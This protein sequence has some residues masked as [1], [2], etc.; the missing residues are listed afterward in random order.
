M[1]MKLKSSF[2]VI[3]SLLC[4]LLVSLFGAISFKNKQIA[5]QEAIIAE[6]LRIEEENRIALEKRNATIASFKGNIINKENVPDEILDVVNEYLTNYFTNMYFL[7][8]NDV[9]DLFVSDY[10]ASLSNYANKLIVESRKLYDFDFTMSKAHFD[11]EVT[12]YYRD[13]QD[14]V[15]EINEDDYFSFN[16]LEGI[17][18][19]C[20]DIFSKIKIRNIDGQYK[21]SYLY[22]EQGFYMMFDDYASNINDL[23]SLYNRYFKE[24]SNTIEKEKDDKQKSI[25][26]SYVSNKTFNTDYDR[27]AAINYA[28]QYYNT[29]NPKWFNYDTTGGNC[30]NYVSQC[31]YAGGIDMDC[32]GEDQWKQYGFENDVEIDLSQKQTGRTASWVQVIYFNSYARNNSGFGL[33]AEELDNCYYAEPG[34]VIQVGYKDSKNMDHSTIVSKVINQHILVDSNSLDMKD[35]PIEAYTYPYRLLIKILGSN[36]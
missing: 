13:G 30:Q 7:E 9:S 2:I 5:I 28:N 12:S 29:R 10:Y 14:Y 34:D 16:F 25:T 22:K 4:M 36:E 11:Y 17:E 33:V 26:N 1:I 31:L 23:P 27:I 15:V 3:T 6:Q 24:I 8:D 20:Y 32:Y 18:S 19:S 21:I 35:F